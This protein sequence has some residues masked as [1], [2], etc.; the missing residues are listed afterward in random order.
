MNLNEEEVMEKHILDISISCEELSK[1][2]NK[3]QEKF[4]DKIY[5][6]MTPEQKLKMAEIGKRVI[7]DDILQRGKKRSRTAL[8][9]MARAVN[10]TVNE[11]KKRLN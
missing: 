4:I 3:E 6:S 11:F 10:V 2:T 9:T 8:R 7:K 1:M 5:D